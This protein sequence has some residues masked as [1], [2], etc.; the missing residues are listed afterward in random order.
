MRMGS[1]IDILPFRYADVGRLGIPAGPNCNL[2]TVLGSDRRGSV[3][4]RIPAGL[5]SAFAPADYRDSPC[6]P[7]ASTGIFP[8]LARI[9]DVSTH[10]FLA[11]PVDGGPT[12]YDS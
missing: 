3:K 10:S 2:G 1:G 4:R 11:G 6:V 8:R 5:E 7:A 9:F 12:P